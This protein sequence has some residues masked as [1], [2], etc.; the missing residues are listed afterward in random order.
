MSRYRKIDP[1]IWKDEKFTSVTN[2]EKLVVLYCLT[3]QS[4]RIG[5]F[6][7]SCAMA[8]EELDIPSQTFT[9]RFKNVC[10]TFKWEYDER[11]RVLYIPTWWKYNPPENKNN[12][13]G[14][15]KDIDDLPDSLLINKF[16]SNLEYLDET[17]YETFTQTL[18]KHYPKRSP[19]QEQEQEQ[20]Q[21]KIDGN[22][23]LPPKK[24]NVTNLKDPEPEKKKYERY[25]Y[26]TDDEYLWLKDKLGEKGRKAYI[27]RLDGYISQIGV[28]AAAKKYK[29]HYDTILNWNRKDIEEGKILPYREE[30]PQHKDNSP[31][32][33][34]KNK[35]GTFYYSKE[36]RNITQEEY[37]VI[38]DAWR[39][40]HPA[41]APLDPNIKTIVRQA[42]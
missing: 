11:H 35:D 6:L 42:I 22:P 31:P 26:L 24:G 18:E 38:M 10:R 8:A 3:A 12:V 21:E 23:P 1:R 7:F 34:S 25:V 15:L 39:K 29:S 32:A 17:F 40:A 9:K 16:K 30:A 2:D 4:N 27:D 36:E 13:I 33:L 37:D 28:P 14:N 19:S 20:E 5:L 41:A